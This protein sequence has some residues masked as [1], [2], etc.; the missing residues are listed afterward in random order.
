MSISIARPHGEVAV[1]D[2][3]S[4]LI[5]QQAGSLREMNYRDAKNYISAMN[6]ERFAGY[7]D[8]RLP[9]LEEAISLVEP[10]KKDGGLH[11][12]PVFDPCQK[13]V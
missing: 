12:N 11:I 5:W 13:R 4:G 7:H 8:W 3:I 2:H 6:K 9:T 1:Y 10:A